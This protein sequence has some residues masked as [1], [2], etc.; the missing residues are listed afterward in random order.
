[1]GVPPV[2][3]VLFFLGSS[4]LLAYY[5]FSMGKKYGEHGL[6]MLRAKQAQPKYMVVRNP[7]LFRNLKKR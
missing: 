7:N 1:M 2:I 5:V 6:M 3:A 4:G